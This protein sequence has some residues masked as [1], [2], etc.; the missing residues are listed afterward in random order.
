MT[1]QLLTL[2]EL[3]PLFPDFIP[4]EIIEYI[5]KFYTPKFKIGQRCIRTYKPEKNSYIPNVGWLHLVAYVKKQNV[6]IKSIDFPSKTNVFSRPREYFYGY[7]YFPA[8]E[9]FAYECD[10]RPLTKEEEGK[11]HWELPH[12]MESE[13]VSTFLN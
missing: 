10:L 7:D 9:G 4:T 8:S 6:V 13:L 2:E 5:Y 11:N 1:F 12:D 3:I